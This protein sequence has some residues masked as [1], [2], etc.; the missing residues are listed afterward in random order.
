M[1]VISQRDSSVPRNIKWSPLPD[2]LSWTVP[3]YQHQDTLHP[4][5]WEDL[6]F[7][8]AS[9]SRGGLPLRVLLLP[10]GAWKPEEVGGKTEKENLR[11]NNHT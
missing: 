10:C 6:P 9:E 5:T 11:V 1:F 8:T 4:V 7:S 3:E 2:T